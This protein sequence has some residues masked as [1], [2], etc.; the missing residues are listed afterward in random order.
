MEDRPSI[1]MVAANILNKQLRTADKGRYSSLGVGRGANNSSP[2]KRIMLQ[3]WYLRPGPGLILWYGLSNG[4]GIWDLVHGLWWHRRKWGDNIKLDLQR[5]DVGAMDWIDVVQNRD[6][7]LALVNA[8]MK[9][10]LGIAWL[11]ENLLASPEGLCSLEFGSYLV[12]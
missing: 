4:K 10:M 2:W 12:T 6:K 3:N 5:W 1:R 7:W 11:T 9:L 8:V